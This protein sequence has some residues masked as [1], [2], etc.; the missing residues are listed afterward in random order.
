[1]TATSPALVDALGR[2]FTAFAAHFLR[3]TWTL[4]DFRAELA[5]GALRLLLPDHRAIAGRPSAYLL[6]AGRFWAQTRPELELP[7]LL[8]ALTHAPLGAGTWDRWAELRA[9]RRATAALHDLALALAADAPD[10]AVLIW[11]RLHERDDD[12]SD[13]DDSR[14]GGGRIPAPLRAAV[15]ARSPVLAPLVARRSHSPMGIVKALAPSAGAADETSRLALAVCLDSAVSQ[16]RS[17][18]HLRLHAALRPA[19]ERLLAPGDGAAYE[20]ALG[21]AQQLAAKLHHVQA[22]AEARPLLDLLIA[23]GVGFPETLRQRW[24]CRLDL[25]DPG[26]ESDWARAARLDAP[27]DPSYLGRCMF[28]SGDAS[29]RRAL[30]CSRVAQ[31]LVQRAAGGDPCRDRKPGAPVS[32]EARARLLARAGR[33]AAEALELAA[34]RVAADEAR[35]RAGESMTARGFQSELFAARAAVREATGDLAGALADYEEARTLRVAAGLSWQSDHHGDDVRR[36]ERALAGAA[37]PAIPASFDPA[38]L[39]AA[40]RSAGERAQAIARWGAEPWRSFPA[41]PADALGTPLAYVLLRELVAA[42]EDVWSAAAGDGVALPDRLGFAARARPLLDAHAERRDA[43]RLAW[44][45]EHAVFV[46]LARSGDRHDFARKT[47]EE[48]RPLLTWLA[49]LAA[50]PALDARAVLAGLAGPPW[51]RLGDLFHAKV[52]QLDP[53]REIFDAA[54]GAGLAADDVAA[55]VRAYDRLLHNDWTRF[56]RP[57]KEW[58]PLGE[59]LDCPGAARLAPALVA[60][61][62]AQQRVPGYYGLPK[63]DP[64][65][66]WPLFYAWAPSTAELLREVAEGRLDGGKRLTAPQKKLR[67]EC[68]QWFADAKGLT[69]PRA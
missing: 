26:A 46:A 47:K 55:V 9:D 33:L 23:A 6:L 34:E 41:T 60:W 35:A 43:D 65:W 61:T 31:G 38:W 39:T 21:V 53:L 7:A 10:E 17:S 42:S 54:R 67:R 28:W 40:E 25:D 64:K 5:D 24:E 59:A 16:L 32:A 19:L 29:D 50:A 58:L 27:G 13:R 44:A 11:R 45:L 63:L 22:Y 37:P 49:A 14:P 52:E 68:L 69:L 48:R 57:P 4:P 51:I 20:V 62:R 66:L 30:A 36:L 2:L 3:G 18:D 12:W 56:A 8:P 1:M 15:L